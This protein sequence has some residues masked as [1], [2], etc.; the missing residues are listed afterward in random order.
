VRHVDADRERPDPH[1]A[2]G[3][4]H[5]VVL[6]PHLGPGDERR[7]AVHEVRGVALGVELDEVVAEHAA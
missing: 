1:L 3:V 7:H 5:E 4:P 2:P 6:A